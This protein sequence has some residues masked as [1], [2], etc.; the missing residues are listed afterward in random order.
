MKSF[1]LVAVKATVFVS[2]PEALLSPLEYFPK[3]CKQAAD[4]VR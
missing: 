1:A 4:L 3:N 2:L